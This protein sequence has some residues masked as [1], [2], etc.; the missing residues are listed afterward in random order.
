MGSDLY[1]RIANDADIPSDDVQKN[2]LATSDFAKGMQTDI[3]HYM[4][5]DKINNASFR[6]KLD[7]I[8]KNILRRQ[9]SLELVFEDIST[10]DAENLIAGSLFRELDV[11]KKDVASDLIKKVP[12]PPGL[13]FVIQNRLSKLKEGNEN[14]NNSYN[15]SPPPSSSPPSFLPQQPLPPPLPSPFHSSQ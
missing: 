4:T 12:G 8:N 1:G 14:I 11:G 9:N 10:F 15:L 2:L 3:N 5:R 13:D 7:P 6:Q